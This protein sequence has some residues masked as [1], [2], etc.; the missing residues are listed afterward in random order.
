MSCCRQTRADL[1]CD[2]TLLLFS[3]IS[4]TTSIKVDLKLVKSPQREGMNRFSPEC[5]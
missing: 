1:L 5:G 2:E 3:E 4:D